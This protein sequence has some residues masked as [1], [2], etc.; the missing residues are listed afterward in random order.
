M[1]FKKDGRVTASTSFIVEAAGPYRRQGD[2]ATG[3]QPR[4]AALPG[5]EHALPRHLGGDQHAAGRL[6]ARAGRTAELR[7][8]SSRW[9]TRP[10]ASSGIDQVAIRKINAPVRRGTVRARA[11][12]RAAGTTAQ[13]AHQLLRQG[14]AR[15]GRRA[16]QLGGAQEAQRPAARQQGDRRGRRPAAPSPRARSASTAS[17][18]SSPTA[19]STSTRASATSARTR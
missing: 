4:D 11:G 17:S 19:S 10:R 5:A 14:G 1:G 2:H 9:S 15:Q 12:Q 8:C 16:V 13:Q 6:A 18:S 3:R 7:C